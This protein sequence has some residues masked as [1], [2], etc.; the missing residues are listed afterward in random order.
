MTFNH[1]RLLW[2]DFHSLPPGASDAYDCIQYAFD[3]NARRSQRLSPMFLL[4]LHARTLSL[5]TP[6]E[7]LASLCSIMDFV[8]VPRYLVQTEEWFKWHRDVFRV[9]FAAPVVEVTP[10]ES[11]PEAIAKLL[12]DMLK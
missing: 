11:L 4:E 3:Y 7:K 10:S 5:W 9:D 2:G 1:F 6:I 12:I 8:C